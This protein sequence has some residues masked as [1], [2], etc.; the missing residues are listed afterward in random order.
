M[1][2]TGNTPNSELIAQWYK[3]V[4]PNLLDENIVWEKAENFL[5]GGVAKGRDAIFKEV[6]ASIHEAFQPWSAVVEEIFEGGDGETVIALGHYVGK[7]LA[8][9]TDVSAPFAHVWRV[10]EGKIIFARQY[11]DTLG[12]AKAQGIL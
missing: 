3:T 8:T 7:A 1:Q 2:L 10:R 12:I 11:T 4:N 6:F 5:G 9:G